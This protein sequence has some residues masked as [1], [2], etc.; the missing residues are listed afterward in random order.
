MTDMTGVAIILKRMIV[1]I[2]DKAVTM[3]T[4]GKEAVVLK[5]TSYVLTGANNLGVECW[6]TGA[7]S[8]EIP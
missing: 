8:L 7:I 3:E 5:N 4:K 1:M 6:T 2:M